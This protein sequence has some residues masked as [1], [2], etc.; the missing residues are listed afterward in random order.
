M[1]LGPDSV[2][3]PALSRLLVQRRIV[4]A[5]VAV[6]LLIGLLVATSRS[7]TSTIVPDLMGVR[8][9]PQLDAL[10]LRLETAGLSLDDVSVAPCPEFDIPGASLERV[11]GTIVDQQPPAGE[12]VASSTKVDVTVCL[13]DQQR[14]IGAGV[15]S[16][17]PPDWLAVR[18]RLPVRQWAASYP[19]VNVPIQTP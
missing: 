7:D 9:D 4:F 19:V 14:R 13:P 1:S 16:G 17:P 15:P 12:Q 8:V 3:A 10:R 6:A 11:P 5:A 2:E 18:R